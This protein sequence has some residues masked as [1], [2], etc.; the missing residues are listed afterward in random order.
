MHPP[1]TKMLPFVGAV[2]LKAFGPVGQEVRATIGAAD[3][4]DVIEAAATR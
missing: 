1:L 3:D 4:R 2:A